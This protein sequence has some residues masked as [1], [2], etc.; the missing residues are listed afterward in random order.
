MVVFVKQLISQ[1]QKKWIKD[2]QRE[3][4]G[5]C[6]EKDL[7]KEKLLKIANTN[8]HGKQII[9][10]EYWRMIKKYFGIKNDS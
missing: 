8:K 2:K 10:R 5:F 7:V 4:S 6:M 3:K 1:D 9:K